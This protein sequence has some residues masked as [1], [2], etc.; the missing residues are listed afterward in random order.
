M[1]DLLTWVDF[2]SSPVE[3]P[4]PAISLTPWIHSHLGSLLIDLADP[5]ALLPQVVFQDFPARN[6]VLLGVLKVVC[7]LWQASPQY[8]L[9]PLVRI[10]VL[11]VLLVLV[12]LVVLVVL[13]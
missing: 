12:V 10:V 4:S 6:R 8:Y 7:H 9:E 2:V 13:L 5:E 1:N 11:A 3:C